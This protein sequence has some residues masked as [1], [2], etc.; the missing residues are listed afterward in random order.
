M[1][2]AMLLITG[3]PSNPCIA[4]YANATCVAKEFVT[5]FNAPRGHFKAVLWVHGSADVIKS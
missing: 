2:P 1:F 4:A 3:L 5:D